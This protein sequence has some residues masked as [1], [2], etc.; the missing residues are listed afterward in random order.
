MTMLGTIVVADDEALAR[1]S[2][3]EFLREEGYQVYEAADGQAALQLLEQ[4][5]VDLILSDLRMPG[6]DGLAVLQKVREVY[7]QTMVVLMTAYASVETV[8]EALRLGAQDYLLKP[9]LFDDLLHKVRRLLENKRQAWEIQLLR[10]E[11]SR[12]FDFTGM[13]GRSPAMKEIFEL[14]KKVAP[15]NATVL[16]TGESGVGKEVVARLMHT[17]SVQKDQVFLPVNC[18]AIPEALLE[19]QL[20]GHTK[21]AFTGAIG[22]QDGLFQHARSGTIFLDEIGE[23]PLTLQPK[24]LRAI[25]EKEV[26]PVGATTP[27]KIDVRILA[28]TNRD[29]K[30]EIE[31]GRFREDLYYRL[32][33]IELHIPPLRD[34]REDIPLLVK[35]LVQRHNQE[36]KKAYKGVDNATM[37]LLMSLP[38]KGN[39]RELDNVL[40]RAMILGDGEWISPT[41]LP[42]LEVPE[43]TPII[44]LSDN[45]K[46]AIQA[47]EKSHIETVLK[48]TNGDKKSAAELLGLSLSSLYRKLDEL[49]LQR[50]VR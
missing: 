11:V 30:K 14:V 5:D 13:V 10:R 7:P 41:D 21:G 6:V 26:L 46:E 28:A 44:S 22:V 34:R 12:H 15:T 17:H 4:V 29:L 9:L 2:V 31:A 35:H 48:K 33:V 39:V 45:L 20:F 43:G 50:D 27:I 3:V 38:W 37:K 36:M 32:N 49:G 16:I 42:R 47:Y 1:Q 24:L 40:E 19:S 25:E 18:S 23:M 8:V